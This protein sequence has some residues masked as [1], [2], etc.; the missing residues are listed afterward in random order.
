KKYIKA[1]IV[2]AFT[3]GLWVLLFSKANLANI[4][5]VIHEADFRTILL[6]LALSTVGNI[7]IA[8][9]R[10]KVVLVQLGVPMS[11][12]ES[13][14][15]KMGSNVIIGFLPFRSG[16]A[17]RLLYLTRVKNSSYVKASLSILIEYLIKIL[18][19]LS[20]TLLG[21]M[22]YFFHVLNLKTFENS[23]LRP[24]F[25]CLLGFSSCEFFRNKFGGSWLIIFK[26]CFRE[27]LAILRNKEVLFYTTLILGLEMANFYL[28]SKALSMNLPLYALLTF[29]PLAILL[30]SLP[31]T[32]AG[33]GTREAATLFLFARFS[34]SEILVSLGILV[35]FVDHL[36]PLM[37]GLLVT[38]RF[39]SRIVEGEEEAS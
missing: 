19:L 22:T 32:V 21:L 4:I 7:F 1:T 26:D 20:C 17:S 9:Y 25:Y 27:V 16:E 36:F 15:I 34:S 5:N 38:G 28:L 12:K 11:F 2:L 3:I 18:L 31:V 13:L 37:V 14:L 8:A 10:W 33:L 6:C 39:V 24:A 29:A 35:F 30:G 23:S